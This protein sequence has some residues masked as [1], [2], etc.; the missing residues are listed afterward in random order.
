MNK[1]YK[2][3]SNKLIQTWEIEVEGAKF[4]THEGILDGVITTSEWTY[5]KGK[6]E[7]RAN[8]TSPEE[9]AHKEALAKWTKKLETYAEDLA[10][11]HKPKFFAP[12]LAHPLETYPDLNFPVFSSPK[13]DGMR[14]LAT[15][16][17]LFSRNGKP[18]VSAPHIHKA[19]KKLFEEST[20]EVLDGELYTHRFASDFNKIISLA[21]KTK[22]TKEDLEESAKYLQF[23]VFDYYCEDSPRHA[24]VEALFYYLNKYTDSSIIKVVGQEI[25]E[26]REELDATYLDYMAMG[27]EGQMIASYEGPYENKRSK[28]L[29]K[30]KTFQ[31]AEFTLLDILPGKGNLAEMAA[32]A[33][34]EGFDAGVIGDHTYARNLL[35]NKHKVIGRQ[36]TVMF[37]NLTPEGVPRFPKMKVIRDYE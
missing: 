7:G 26:D 22:P 37:Q 9:Q 10:H 20:I 16:E 36:A 29:L 31:D 8:A 5:V 12:M 19:L 17:G 1:L 6:N 3:T 25:I 4:R 23:W 27:Y 30:R 18:I 13:L 33:R 32:V 2:L 35:V 11:I 34:F 14:C 28:H 15:K 24:R 21:K